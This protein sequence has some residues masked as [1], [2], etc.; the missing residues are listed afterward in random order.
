MVPLLNK[1][2]DVRCSFK[3]L[4]HQ[5]KGVKSNKSLRRNTERDFVNVHLTTKVNYAILTASLHHC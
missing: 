3:K 1:D 4:G 5:H 2:G